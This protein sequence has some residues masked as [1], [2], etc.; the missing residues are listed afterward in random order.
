MV[1]GSVLIS[2]VSNTTMNMIGPLEATELLPQIIV[3]KG[4]IITAE[5]PCVAPAVCQARLQ[6][7]YTLETHW[8]LSMKPLTRCKTP[9]PF[10]RWGY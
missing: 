3:I 1:S 9:C 8:V 7:L 4:I 10:Y 5:D 2:V 6:A